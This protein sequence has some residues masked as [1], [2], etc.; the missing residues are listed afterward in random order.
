MSTE[1][2]LLKGRMD[3]VG[4]ISLEKASSYVLTIY[5]FNTFYEILWKAPFHIPINLVISFVYTFS[6]RLL[7]FYSH[8][9]AYF[10]YFLEP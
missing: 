2:S 9:R 5:I 8:T 3:E 1:R 6:A 10:S 4:R 7:L